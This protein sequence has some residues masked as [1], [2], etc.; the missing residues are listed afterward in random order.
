MSSTSDIR[1]FVRERAQYACEFCGVT[2]T[3]TGG[4]LTVDH[5]QPRAR[6]G[7]DESS[8]LLYCCVR[9]NQYKADYWPRQPDDPMLWH[10]RQESMASHLLMLAD[11]TLYPLTPV[12]EFTVRRLRLNRP[13]LV[14]YRLRQR[15]EAEEAQLLLRYREIVVALE[16]LHEQQVL[17]LEEHRALLQEQRSILRLLLGE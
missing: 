1:S 17:L 9:C 3:D 12:G 5:F 2:E 7:S 6:G 13:P 10:P 16:R 11:G 4:E 14:A 15:Q 8:N